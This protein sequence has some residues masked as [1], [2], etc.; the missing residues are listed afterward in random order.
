MSRITIKTLQTKVE[1]MVLS[2]GGKPD[3]DMMDNQ[4]IQDEFDSLS[5]ILK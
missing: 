4:R 3:G 1:F 5:T 2:L